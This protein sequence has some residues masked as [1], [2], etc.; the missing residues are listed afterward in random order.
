[1]NR[2]FR[3]LLMLTLT[4]M[5]CA[6][7]STVKK[8]ETEETAPTPAPGVPAPMIADFVEVVLVGYWEDE[9]YV[10]NWIE[11]RKI[12][13]R[14]GRRFGWR[15]KLKEPHRNYVR[16]IER[17]ALPTA[18]QDWGELERRHLV[19]SDRRVATVP[20][21]LKVRDDWIA[22]ANWTMSEGDALGLHTMEIQVDG[23]PA[24]RVVFWLVEDATPATS[25]E[26]LHEDEVEPDPADTEEALPADGGENE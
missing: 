13:F 22:R 5:L 15:M 19:S 20:N 8:M 25:E 10:S 24:A 6:C 4:T 3:W 21:D 9:P 11:T 2:G 26:I 14:P 18:P 1:M 16:I 17:L 7:L 23:R 12:P